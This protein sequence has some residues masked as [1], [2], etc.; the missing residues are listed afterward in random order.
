MAEEIKVEK[1]AKPQVEVGEYVAI[2]DFAEILKLPVTHVISTLMKNG[3]MATINDTIDFDT[4]AIIGDE[5]GY[6]V[7]KATK[8]TEVS[9]GKEEKGKMKTRPPVVTIMGHVDHGKTSLL[10][11]IRSTNVVAGEAG[12]ITQ[13][14]GAYQV[15]V[16][17]RSASSADGPKRSKKKRLITF[18][19]TPGHEAFTAMRAHGANITDVVILVVAADDSVKPQTVEAFNHSRAANVPVVVAITKIDKPGADIMR[20]KSDLAVIGL[21]TEEWGGTTVVMPVNNKTGEGIPELLDMVIL[22]ADLK[23]LKARY[24]GLA[25][26]VVIESHLSPGMGPVATIL[27]QQGILNVGDAIVAGSAMGKIKSMTDWAG[28]KVKIAEPSMPVQISGLSAV[29]NFG[30][31]VKEYATDSEAKDA[32][33]KN[34]R[35][36]SAKKIKSSTFGIAELSAAIREGKIKELNMVLKADVQGSLEAIKGVLE[37]AG[38]EDVKVKVVSEGVGGISEGDVAMAETANAMLV[39]FHVPVFPAAKKL[40]E[41][42]KVNIAIYDIIYNLADDIYMAMEGLLEPEIV[43]VEIGKG[44]ILQIFFTEK[45]LKIIGCKI[46]EGKVEKGAFTRFLRGEQALGTARI[47][48]LKVVKED[49]SEV[50]KGSECGISVEANFK[51][52]EGDILEFYKKEEIL[53]K[54]QK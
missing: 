48:A 6:E 31:I 38:T 21:Q 16:V 26:G 17:E 54:L 20:V 28:K 7:T 19:D 18:L 47:T 43:D 52:K 44:E 24:E 32:A 30:E 35:E 51:I 41:Q 13:H 39:G 8:V 29:P 33:Q 14:I 36:Q 11:K 42:K 1:P 34:Q 2:R 49:V 25:Q 15:E 4:A 10:D 3:V 27:I 45:S 53:K 5:L 40:A 12:G 9:E 50:E 46:T 22:V 37:K 23:E